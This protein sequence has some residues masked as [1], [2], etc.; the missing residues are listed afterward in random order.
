MCLYNT[1]EMKSLSLTF[2]QVVLSRSS[3]ESEYR[4]LIDATRELIWIRDLLSKLHL[5]PSTRTKLYC[6]NTAAIQ[7]TKNLH[8]R[9]HIEVGRHLVRQKITKGKIIQ[10]Q[11]VSSINQLADI[12]TKPLG[13]SRIQSMCDKLACLMYMLHLKGECLKI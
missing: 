9:K 13:G 3:D 11:Y 12:L 1:I 7:N 8:K 5:L 6:N 2:S 4:A 10:L